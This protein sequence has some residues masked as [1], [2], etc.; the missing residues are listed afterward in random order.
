MIIYKD[1]EGKREE[2]GMGSSEKEK[3]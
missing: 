1:E 3:A 2:C